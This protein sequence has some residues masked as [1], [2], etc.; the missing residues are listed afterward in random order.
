MKVFFV[1]SLTITLV[2]CNTPTRNNCKAFQTGRFFQLSEDSKDTNLVF[3]DSAFQIEITGADTFMASV[4]WIDACN[5]DLT[6]L[7][8]KSTSPLVIGKT[9][10]VRMIKTTK[11]YYLYEAKIPGTNLFDKDTLIRIPGR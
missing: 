9:I 8:S 2:S 5:Y 11:D 1:I 6:Y 7:A 4:K 10:K 3:R